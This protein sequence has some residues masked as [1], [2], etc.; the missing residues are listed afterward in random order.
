MPLAKI[1]CQVPCMRPPLLPPLVI[2]KK[3]VYR[4]HRV[5]S[6]LMIS[7]TGIFRVLS[8]FLSCG[9]AKLCKS[10]EKR[11][12]TG[13]SAVLSRVFQRRASQR[14]GCSSRISRQVPTWTLDACMLVIIKSIISECHC[15]SSADWSHY[16]RVLQ[17]W[18][19]RQEC[20]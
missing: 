15:R 11:H 5:T 2:V 6:V 18:E 1:V 3:S 16:H 14:Y 12:M 8:K 9:C 10:C 13:G 19:W 17:L 4:S 7:V 20:V